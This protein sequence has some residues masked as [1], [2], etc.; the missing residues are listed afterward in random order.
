MSPT[1]DPTIIEL[2]LSSQSEPVVVETFITTNPHAAE[3]K[4]RE[5]RDDSW[6]RTLEISQRIWENGEVIS[7]TDEVIY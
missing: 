1:T 4:K 6:N 3:D 7:E 5:W 2:R